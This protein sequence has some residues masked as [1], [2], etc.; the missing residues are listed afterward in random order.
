MYSQ[1]GKV[2]SG[3]CDTYM[4]VYSFFLSDLLNLI[5][6]HKAKIEESMTMSFTAFASISRKNSSLNSSAPPPTEG[7]SLGQ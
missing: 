3:L 6:R 7:L 5:L 2:G 1:I 4:I